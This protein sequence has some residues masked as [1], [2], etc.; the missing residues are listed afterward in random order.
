L[1]SL[2]EPN[3]QDFVS[4]KFI[5]LLLPLVFSTQTRCAPGGSSPKEWDPLRLIFHF[6]RCLRLTSLIEI[7][8]SAFDLLEFEQ[9]RVRAP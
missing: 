7:N 3:H 8:A 6:K 9:T 1:G 5:E 4:E 2:V